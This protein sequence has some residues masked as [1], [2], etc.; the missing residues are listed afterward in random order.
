MGPQRLIVRDI[1]HLEGLSA[2]T[3]AATTVA[4]AIAGQPR[5]EAVPGVGHAKRPV[6]KNLD[7]NFCDPADLFYLFNGNFAGQHHA[8]G[9]QFFIQQRTFQVIDPHLRGAVSFQ[10]HEVSYHVIEDRHILNDDTV[11][12]NFIQL[13]QLVL[14]IFHFFFV[15]HGIHS[16]KDFHIAQMGIANHVRQRLPVK[17]GGIRSGAKLL[18]SQIHSVA[19]VG[20]RRLERFY[21]SSRS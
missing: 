16:H 20:Y 12:T 3:H 8:L 13:T 11:H 5:H 10:I 21:I 15:D 19:A 1:D 2:R 17:I 18:H 7:G 4:A 9:S 6:N 14:H